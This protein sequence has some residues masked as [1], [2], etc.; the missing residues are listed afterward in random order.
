MYA[1][2]NGCTVA[3][4]R[5]DGELS[6]HQLKSFCHADKANTLMFDGVLLVKTN[7]PITHRQLNFLGSTAQFHFELSRA[8]MLNSILCC[9]L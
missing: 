2:V 5:N 4:L 7:T 1:G 9:F 8:A 6:I 3:G